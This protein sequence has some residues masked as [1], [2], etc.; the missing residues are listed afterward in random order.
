MSGVKPSQLS[1]ATVAAMKTKLGVMTQAE[2]DL[3][4]PQ[5]TEGEA[6]EIYSKAE[7]DAIKLELQ[8]G[9]FDGQI[10]RL[11]GINIVSPIAA[12]RAFEGQFNMIDGYNYTIL[13]E[14]TDTITVSAFQYI[15]AVQG[16]F[17]AD[18]YNGI[19]LYSYNAT[20]KSYTKIIETDNDATI[21]TQAA[22]VIKTKTFTPQVL[23]PGFYAVAIVYNSSAQTTAPALY[24]FGAINAAVNQIY[25]HYLVGMKNATTSL[26]ASINYTDF[27]M[28]GGTSI[29]GII[30]K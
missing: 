9:K 7:V 22:G 26:P 2:A 23:T 24:H 18:N 30:L 11:T 15:L 12:V 14:I 21:W 20:T 25:G 6:I 1:A 27:N 10:K 8:R 17:T 5:I 29:P 3:R 13:Y 19:A 28:G 4:Y 16:V